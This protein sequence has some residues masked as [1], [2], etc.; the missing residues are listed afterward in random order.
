M[1]HLGL[2]HRMAG[3]WGAVITGALFALFLMPIEA[4]SQ[5]SSPV[6]KPEWKV[7]DR[8]IH[9]RIDLLGNVKKIQFDRAVRSSDDGSYVL[10]QSTKRSDGAETSDQNIRRRIDAATL[11][12]EDR[13]VTSGRQVIFMF[14]L[15]PGQTWEYQLVTKPSSGFAANR[16]TR[17]SVV[18]WET[19]KVSAGVFRAL[20]VVHSTDYQPIDRMNFAAGTER[21]TLWYCPEVKWFVKREWYHVHGGRP[22]DHSVDELIEFEVR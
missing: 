4:V 17:V 14:P 1:K 22:W 16:S 13:N 7:G 20:K 19:V 15:E 11:T 12:F 5:T 6:E 9:R 3:G 8:W 21:L 10:S 18:G 2:G